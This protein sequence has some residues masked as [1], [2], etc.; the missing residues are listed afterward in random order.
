M[1]AR[2]RRRSWNR[3]S[4]SRR[5]WGSKPR[6]VGIGVIGS[7]VAP[8]W[9]G[10]DWAAAGQPTSRQRIR[11]RYAILRHCGSS[12]VIKT[13]RWDAIGLLVINAFDHFGPGSGSQKIAKSASRACSLP[14]ERVQKF[15]IFC[16]F[17]LMRGC[18]CLRTRPSRDNLRTTE[19]RGRC[20]PRQDH[21]AVMRRSFKRA[22]PRSSRVIEQ[23]V[24]IWATDRLEA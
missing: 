18:C 17:P 4:P 2:D 19:M 24:E 3:R 16:L 15:L 5:R 21:R 7:W 6:A 14:C 9:L 12:D 23:V 10:G 8:A 20:L 11:T 1:S 13:R 22:R